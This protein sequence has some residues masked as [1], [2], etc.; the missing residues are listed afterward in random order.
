MTEEANDKKV[1]GEKSCCVCSKPSIKVIIGIVLIIIGLA[2][3]ISWWSNL[4]AMLKGCIGLLLI[5]A[6]AIAIAIAKE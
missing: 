4:L 2:A 1:D 6:G 5:M 3:V